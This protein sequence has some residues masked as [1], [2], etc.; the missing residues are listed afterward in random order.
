VA[1]SAHPYAALTPDVMLDAVERFG[2][3]CDGT[4]LALNSY[5][6]RVYQVGVEG[7]APVIAKFYRPRRWSREAILEEHAFSL[8]L[9]EREIPVVA[10]LSDPRSRTLLEH[11]GFL[12]TLY[13]RRGGRAPELDDAATLAW[14]GRFLGRMHAL[15]A[16]RAF[17]HR[18][19]VEIE[20]YGRRPVAFVLASGFVPGDIHAAY[21][22][23]T[24]EALARVERLFGEVPDYRAI[25]VHGDCHASN[26]LWAS[27]GPHFVDLDDCR[28][29]PAVQD[30]W[31][32]ISGERD[33]R[34]AQIANVLEGYCEFHD[35]DARELRLVEALRTLRILHYA[36]WLARRW[37][38]P[39][40][41]RNFPWFN[42]SRYW[43]GQIEALHEQC[44]NMDEPPLAWLG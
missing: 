1:S 22:A 8:A 10:P 44:A 37:D 21:A 3:R 18:P 42:T 6:N 27:G 43:E 5:E 23:V 38:D 39:A 19:S 4:F 35:F 29:G 9:A 13:P 30:L 31:M 32:L 24:T 11:Q 12:Y 36:A 33:E 7:D 34:A 15:G 41:P 26:I 14:L 16:V 40:F 17:R 25:R 28:M 20:S 2:L